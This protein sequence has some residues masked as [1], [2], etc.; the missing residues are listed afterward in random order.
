MFSQMLTEGNILNV[1]LNLIGGK[2]FL[3]V[4]HVK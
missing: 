1:K 2:V 3:I 4:I